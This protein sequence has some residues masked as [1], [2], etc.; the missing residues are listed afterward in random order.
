VPFSNVFFLSNAY[1][2]C[3]R[4]ALLFL[5]AAAVSAVASVATFEPVFAGKATRAQTLTMIDS[6]S[7]VR[8]STDIRALEEAGGHNS[9]VTFTPGNDSAVAFLYRSFLAIPGLASVRL[10]TFYIDADT[11]YVFK[12]LVNVVATLEGATQPSRSIVVGA[13][14][15][16]SASRMGTSTWRSQWKTIRAP[17]ADDN[18]SGTAAMLEAAR[19]MSDPSFGILND[20]TITF[21]AFGSEEGGPAH[22]GGHGGS[23]HYAGQARTRG[24]DILGMISVDMIGHNRHYTTTDVVSNTPS[25][26]LGEA[27]V[28]AKDSLS[29]PLITNEPPFAYDDNDYSD[30]ASFWEYGYDAILLIEHAAPWDQSTNYNPNPYYHRTS[31]TIETLNYNLLKR[32]TQ[33]LI[34]TLVS[35][36]AAPTGVDDPPVPAA[37]RLEQNY[38]N[39]FNPETRIRFAVGGDRAGGTGARTTAHTT[40]R[41]YDML[42]REVAL[43]VDERKAAGDYEVTFSARDGAGKILPSGTYVYR[44]SAGSFVESRLMLFLK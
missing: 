10:D 25:V 14:Y 11:P 5:A 42:G 43:L 23:R 36:T 26:W 38:P 20:Y 12:P 34:G 2:G 24:D 13:H 19:L 6:V 16:A 39:P 41:V 35:I 1:L 33:T 3:M 7:L 9:R 17:G 27:F 18:A 32:V 44:L 40:L 28:A 37:A 15:D 31:D 22:R 4:Y 29:V 8:I 21:V 30:H